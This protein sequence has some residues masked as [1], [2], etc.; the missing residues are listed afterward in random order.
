L[1]SR[2]LL[3]GWAGVCVAFVAMA[4]TA[5]GSP[6]AQST[7]SDLGTLGGPGSHAVAIN[8][9]SAAAINNRGQVV[10][11]ADTAAKDA[12]GMAIWHAFL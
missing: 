10:G 6:R 2:R 11:E 5:R 4:A 12:D 1:R 3:R 9:C 7:M 8:E